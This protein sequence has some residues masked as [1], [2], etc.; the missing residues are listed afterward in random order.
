M[1]PPVRLAYTLL[2]AKQRN[3]VAHV[4]SFPHLV[5]QIQN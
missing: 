5:T 2:Y 4:D 3:I 1:Q